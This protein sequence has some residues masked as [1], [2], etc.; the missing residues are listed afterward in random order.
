MEV[1]GSKTMSIPYS[2]LA[3]GQF[4]AGFLGSDPKVPGNLGGGL[5]DPIYFCWFPWLRRK[6]SRPI[7]VEA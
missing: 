4:S 6:G 5:G 1:H 3:W 2:S 7:W